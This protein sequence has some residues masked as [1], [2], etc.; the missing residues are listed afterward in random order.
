MIISIFFKKW[1]IRLCQSI[2]ETRQISHLFISAIFIVPIISQQTFVLVKMTWTRLQR[3]YFFS[4]K[5]SSRCLQ[6]LSIKTNICR[7]SEVP[8]NLMLI[9]MYQLLRQEIVTLHYDKNRQPF[10]S[11]TP[12]LIIFYW[13]FHTP[14]D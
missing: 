5:T 12:P 9:L 8:F 7:D 14:V 13:I 10:Y 4:S 3:N 6:V 1:V 2:V 11:I